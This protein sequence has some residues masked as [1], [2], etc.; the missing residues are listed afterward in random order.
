MLLVGEVLLINSG[1]ERG[2]G[3]PLR[4][5]IRATSPIVE[6]VV[7]LGHIRSASSG[8]SQIEEVRLGISLV[9]EA[10]AAPLDERPRSRAG[11]WDMVIAGLSLA[12]WSL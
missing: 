11:G 2:K 3:N 1:A 5:E 7:H 12:Q 6:D 8:L 4:N 10:V 9:H